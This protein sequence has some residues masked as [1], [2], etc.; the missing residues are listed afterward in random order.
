MAEL[1]LAS[2]L[3]HPIALLG[4]ALILPLLLL[5]LLKPKPKTILFPSTMF[6]RFIEKNKRFASFLQRFIHDPL[7][8]LQLLVVCLAVTA[9]A[10]PYYMATAEVNE[11]ESV[12]MVLDA[13]ASMQAEDANPSRFQAAVAKASELIAGLNK[14]DDVSVILAEN[15]PAAI[16][17]GGTPEAALSV[18]PELR[19]ADTSTNVGDAMMLGKDMLSG[20]TRKKVLYVISDFAGGAGMDPLMARKIAMA[21]GI[22]VELLRVGSGGDNL[23]IVSFEARRSNTRDNELYLAA[24]VR[25]FAQEEKSFKFQVSSEGRTLISE[26]KRLT[27]G[28]EG[29]YYWRPNVTSAEQTVKAEILGG[30]E[31]EV[32]DTAYAVVPA[33]KTTRVLLLTSEGQ[34]KYLHY[35]LDSLR[36]VQAE[37]AVPPVTPDIGQ[38]DVIILGDVKGENILPGMFRDVKNR[39]ARGGTLVVVA[40]DALS[41]IKDPEF[42]SILPVDLIGPGSRETGIVVTEEHEMLNDVVFDNVMAKKYYNVKERDNDTVTIVGAQ[43]FEN[44][45][46]S[47]RRHGEGYVAYVGVNTDPAWSNMYYSS[48]FPILW[49]QML[50]F[51]T[52]VEAQGGPPSMRTGE[53]LTLQGEADVKLPSGATVRTASVFLDKAGLYEVS[54][55]PAVERV[56]ANLLDASESNIT[57]RSVEYV[58]DAGGFTV[59]KEETQLRVE[60]YRWILALVV[61]ALALELWVYRRRGIL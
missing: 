39:V 15:I 61:L 35:M 46:L 8:L 43:V 6:I 1:Q 5:Y 28:E 36:N 4:Y 11:E 42:W 14:K 54:Y 47:Y 21:A 30:D 52:R 31:L 19:A 57:G 12:V 58:S 2:F 16:A 29:F 49:S 32:D 50:N 9:A 41:M 17:S 40:T 27:A 48:S 34:D 24:S 23:G 44:P 60:A 3:A 18:L 7:L 10:G 33:V 22:R 25:N 59:R 26:D 20:S 51:F 13:S 37:Y 56:T 38:Y 53:Y 45:M 55:P